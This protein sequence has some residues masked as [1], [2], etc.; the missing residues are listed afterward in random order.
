MS[1]R[2]LWQ[3]L[4]STF[5]VLLAVTGASTAAAW[6]AARHEAEHEARA[7]SRYFSEAVITS[8]RVDELEH[9]TSPTVQDRLD[10]TVAALL[11]DGTV[12]RIKIWRIVEPGTARLVYSDLAAIDGIEVPIN[13]AL[14]R[15][16]ETWQPVV[17]PVPDDEA[18]RTEQRGDADAVEVYQPFRDEDGNLAAL[19]LYLVSTLDQRVLELVAGSLPLAVG[20][21]VLLMALTLPLALRLARNHA[22]AEA[23]RRELAEEMLA[24]SLTERRRLARL[25]HDGPIQELAVLGMT[26]EH[27]GQE[28]AEQVRD[29]VSRMRGL[30]DDLDPLSVDEGNLGEALRSVAASLPGH[31]ATV[32]VRGD[33][34]VELKGPTRTL[35]YQCATELLRN[36]LIHSGARLV[37]VDLSDVGESVEVR[38][39]DDGVGFDPKGKP[40]GHHGLRLVRWALDGGGGTLDIE[41]GEAGTTATFRVP[42]A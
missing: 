39:S 33:G 34:L 8:L 24:S 20:G 40:E 37:T 4:V 28:A 42:R 13:P 6:W 5:V 3:F 16:L 35:V 21:P 36:A 9:P 7:A 18:H 2:P 23:R 12:Y 30:L 10:R 32:D 29:Q 14:A 31:A 15:A 22:R 26:L 27:D 38:V 11:A 25:L 19:E 17:V 41:S 1:R